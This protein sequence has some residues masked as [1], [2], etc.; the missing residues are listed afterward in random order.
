MT[1]NGVGVSKSGG[2]ASEILEVLMKM[3]PVHGAV[4]AGQMP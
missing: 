3:V 1:V 2:K 4:T